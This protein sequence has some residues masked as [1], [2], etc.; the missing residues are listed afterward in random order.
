MLPVAMIK[1]LTELHT[2][3]LI[4]PVTIIIF[5]LSLLSEKKIRRQKSLQVVEKIEWHL[6]VS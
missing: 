2:F 5:S 4:F 1:K 3:D 6:L